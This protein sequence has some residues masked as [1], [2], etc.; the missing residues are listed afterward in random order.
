MTVKSGEVAMS[1]PEPTWADCHG[2]TNLRNA[3]RLFRNQQEWRLCKRCRRFVEEPVQFGLRVTNVYCLTCTCNE[4]GQELE[5]YE[6]GVCEKCL[7]K[8]EKSL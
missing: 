8:W 1:I 5:G 2:E 6:E 7:L 4:C 3:M